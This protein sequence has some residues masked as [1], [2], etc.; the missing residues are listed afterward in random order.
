M[1]HRYYFIFIRKEYPK[2]SL[3]KQSNLQTARRDCWNIN[4]SLSQYRRRSNWIIEKYKS[5]EERYK[6]VDSTKSKNKDG[7][8]NQLFTIKKNF[9]TCCVH[10]VQCCQTSRFWRDISIFYSRIHRAARKSSFF[11]FAVKSKKK[12]HRHTFE[13]R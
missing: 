9:F 7:D 4:I 8:S 12:R 2:R 5:I 6:F 11:G 3:Y 13:Q 10:K 1:K